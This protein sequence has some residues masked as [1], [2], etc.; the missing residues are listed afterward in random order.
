M[1]P[2]LLPLL[3]LQAHAG[4]NDGPQTS[5]AMPPDTVRLRS[6]FDMD[7][8]T[9][10]GRFVARGEDDVDE[11]AA[12]PTLCSQYISYKMVPGGNVTY[13]ELVAVSSKVAARFSLPLLGGAS[14]SHQS[15]KMT[16]VRYTLT[17]KLQAEV[18]DP[19]AFAACCTDRP[20]QC[21]DRFVGEFLQGTG[22]VFRVQQSESEG[23]VDVKTPQGSGGGS[24][25]LGRAWEQS[26]QFEQPVYFAFKLT[27][28]PYTKVGTAC[29]P[30]VDSPPQ[31]PGGSTFVGVARKPQPSEAKAKKKAL[32][33]A[34]GQ[35]MKAGAGMAPNTDLNK[36]A[37]LVGL[38]KSPLERKV[39][40]MTSIKIEAREWCVE[41]DKTGEFT[42]RVL[43]FVPDYQ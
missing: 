5:T 40:Q 17:G 39:E 19:A 28:T 23:G 4:P 34:R 11:T 22:E 41:Q 26:V 24:F 36:V 35:A 33:D 8:S 15:E 32:S 37:N 9:Y 20:D 43:A 31:L 21:T 14:A 27:E 6:A 2:W 13:D 18:S 16:R 10:L 3:I 42:A 38:G 29:G 25:A 30:W 1:I 7:P 12:M